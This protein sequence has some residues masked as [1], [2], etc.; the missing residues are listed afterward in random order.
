MTEHCLIRRKNKT[1]AK[2]KS[3]MSAMSVKSSMY[4]DAYKKLGEAERK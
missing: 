1:P 2:A 3:V 4:H